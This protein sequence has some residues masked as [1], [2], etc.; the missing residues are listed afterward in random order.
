MIFDPLYLI[1][2][3]VGLVLS[4]GAQA[5]V[6]SATAKWD[7]VATGR[8]LTGAD[9]ARAI[10]KARGIQDVRIEPVDGYLT[11]HYDPSSKTLRLSPGN[12]TGRSVTA[13]GISAHEV[14]HAIQHHDGYLPMQIRQ[15]MVPVANIGTQFGIW[16][17]IIGAIIGFTGLAKLGVLLFAAFVAFTLVTLPVEI[18]ASV[19]ARKALLST[20]LID[21]REAQGVSQVLTAAAATYLASAV[22]AILQLFYW[23]QYAGLL[24]SDD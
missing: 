21:E 11:D 15:Q 16:M 24:G 1:I 2:M 18:D 17:V 23:A 6:K 3:G 4:L 14:G 8:G 19:R 10:L 13:A 7:K 12:F 5:W 22:T 9:V 20:G